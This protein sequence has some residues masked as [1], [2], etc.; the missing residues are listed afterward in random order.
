MNWY[1]C[2]FLKFRFLDITKPPRK[3]YVILVSL[4]PIYAF[5]RLEVTPDTWMMFLIFT[6]GNKTLTPQTY[7]MLRIR[8]VGS[9][10][11]EHGNLPIFLT[12]RKNCVSFGGF[13]KTGKLSDTVT[14][15]FGG[16]NT[17]K[18]PILLTLILLNRKCN[19]FSWT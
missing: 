19:S 8:G 11:V 17:A 15:N 13:R 6:I 4:S 9:Y 3:N 5:Q 12:I 1:F 7:W 14:L 16:R 2:L 10:M 18:V